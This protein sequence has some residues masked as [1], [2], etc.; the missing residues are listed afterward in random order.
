MSELDRIMYLYVDLQSRTREGVEYLRCTTLFKAIKVALDFDRSHPQRHSRGISHD[1]P[2]YR[3][4]E[5][6]RQYRSNNGPEPMDIST[7]QISSRDECRHRNLSFKCRSPTHRST[8]CRHRQPCNDRGNNLSGRNYQQHV[9][10]QHVNNVESHE[11]EQELIVY[12]RFTINAMEI[13][14]TTEVEAIGFESSSIG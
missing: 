14:N 2:R 5:T 13:L 12:D 10:L 9:N 7:A 6:S 11:D 3:S 4:Y 8:Q 1:R